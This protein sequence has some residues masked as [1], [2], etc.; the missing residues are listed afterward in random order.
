LDILPFYDPERD[1][2]VATA[3]V[4]GRW[5]QFCTVE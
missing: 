2:L 5:K 1:T 3:D 4:A